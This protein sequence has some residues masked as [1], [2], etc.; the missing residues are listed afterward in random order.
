MFSCE[1]A[2]YTEL[3]PRLGGFA[4]PKYYGSW[5]LELPLIKSS[6]SRTVYSIL[7]EKVPGIPLAKFNPETHTSGE[8]RNVLAKVHEADTAMHF[9][10][11]THSDLAPRNII[12]DRADLGDPDL[13]IRIIDLDFARVYRFLG[14][15]VPCLMHSRPVSPIERH[16]DGPIVE[17]ED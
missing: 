4:I 12:C 14:L 7:I 16:W 11:V 9:A 10:G 1:A 15:E 8:R 5:K 13:K 17:M 3:D 2:A 6:S